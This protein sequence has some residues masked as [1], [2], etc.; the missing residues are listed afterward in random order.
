MSA[1]ARSKV[2]SHSALSSARL[3]DLEATAYHEAGHAVAHVALEVPFR[4][5]TV[6]PGDDYLGRVEA[7]RLSKRLAIELEQSF[8]SPRDRDR[9]EREIICLFCGPIAQA[10]HAGRRSHR[11]TGSDYHRITDFVF[12]MSAGPDEMRAYRNWLKL[13]AE[14]LLFRKCNWPAVEA[15]ARALLQSITL[16]SAEVRS[17]FTAV[18]EKAIPSLSAPAQAQLAAIEAPPSRSP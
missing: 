1:A 17:L 8:L 9:A 10:C 14:Q 18:Y 12:S 13:R 5:V 4:R 16:S 2:A 3:R 11:A 15:V 6:R 7:G